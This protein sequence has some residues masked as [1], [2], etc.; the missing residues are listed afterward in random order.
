MGLRFQIRDVQ[1]FNA[2]TLHPTPQTPHTA[3]CILNPSHPTPKPLA[4][5][6]Y[7]FYQ[8]P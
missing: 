6:L 7:T 2:C 4:A 8:P 3:H 5:K 1:T